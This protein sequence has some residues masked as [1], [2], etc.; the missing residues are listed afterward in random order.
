SCSSLGRGSVTS[1]SARRPPA[2]TSLT[3]V[4]VGYRFATTVIRRDRCY[5][6]PA[7]TA[8]VRAW[9]PFLCP[10]S[11]TRSVPIGSVPS[12]DGCRLTTGILPAVVQPP[13][14]LPAVTTF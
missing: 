4:A 1:I 14:T 5:L 10:A 6:T 3:T 8:S 11:P 13:G 9:L 2:V 7:P 12:A